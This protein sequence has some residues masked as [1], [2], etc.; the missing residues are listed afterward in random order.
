LKNRPEFDKHKQHIEPLL[1]IELT[2]CRKRL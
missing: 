2:I 1:V